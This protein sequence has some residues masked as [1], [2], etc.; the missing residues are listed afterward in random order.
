MLFYLYDAL[1]QTVMKIPNGVC[2]G[3]SRYHE[4]SVQI[5][6]N[7]GSR[8]STFASG[9]TMVPSRSMDDL[10][11]EDRTVLIHHLDVEGAELMVLESGQKLLRSG[12]IKHLLMEFAPHRWESKREES[13]HQIKTLLGGNHYECQVIQQFRLREHPKYGNKPGALAVEWPG[14][15]VITDWDAVWDHLA[16]GRTIGD[17]YCRYLGNHST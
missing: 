5:N 12:R 14:P 10:I 17:V 15:P 16:K 13:M 8:T 6:R 1:A 11:G 4:G 3:G 9:F 2:G 7:Y